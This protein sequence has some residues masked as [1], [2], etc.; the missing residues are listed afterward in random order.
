MRYSEIKAIKVFCESLAS[1]PDW[2]E[3]V[4]K[5]GEDDFT[6]DN[7]RFIRADAIDEI[8]A[9]EMEGDEYVLGCFSA[10]AIAKATGWP[11]ALIEYAQKGEAFQEIGEAMSREQIENLQKIYSDADGYGNH[12]NGYDFGQEEITIDGTDYYVFDCR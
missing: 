3:V 8:Q 5:A 6:V 10:Y 2:R 11:V 4:E 7:V 9:D 12:F 1:N